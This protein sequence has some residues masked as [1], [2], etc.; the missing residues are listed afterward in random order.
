MKK[1]NVK[2]LVK[3]ELARREYL[4]Y[5]RLVH[6]DDWIVGKHIQLIADELNKFLEDSTKH[7]MVLSLPPQHGKSVLITETLP[8]YRAAKHGE[9]VI[10]GSYGDSLAR[11]FGRAN[12][13]K[14][15]EWGER[16]FGK[17]LT[18]SSDVDL[19]LDDGT[20]I[21]SRG[22]LGG[23]TGEKADFIVIDDPIKNRQEADSENQRDTIWN[24]FRDSF[25]SRLSA[26]GKMV[27][28]MT[29]W[30]EDD[31]VGR[32]TKI[33]PNCVV[34]NIPLEAMENDILGREVGDSLFPEIGKDKAW[35]ERFKRIYVGEEGLRSWNALYQ[36]MPTSQEGN[37]FKRHYFNRFKAT[38]QFVQTIRLLIISVD[39][40]FK[41]SKKS[42]YVSIGVWGKIGAD[43]YLIAKVKERM[44]FV[45]TCDAI[46]AICYQYPRATAKYIEDKANGSA[47][48]SVLNRKI[49]GFI[50][51]TPKESKEAR[52]QAVLPYFEAGNVHIYE[53]RGGD[54]LIEEA[55]QFPLGAHDDDVDMMTQAV[56]VLRRRSYSIPEYVSDDPMYPTQ[57][58]YKSRKVVRP[59][60]FKWK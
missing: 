28:I 49:G 32:L 60:K 44:D 55:A 17:K 59:Q 4:D 47:I 58:Q 13:R 9:R 8:S 15:E 34:V 19:E 42:D 41:D 56:N 25:Y 46:E 54:E 48:I 38:P 52:A 21:L 45:A 1:D 33:E 7:F 14:L 10:I 53:G 36:G 30:H 51:I 26:N 20:E 31:L 2:Q 57:K 35:M 12:R 27:I 39:A 23:V 3:E 50:G 37:L 29:R 5:C 22:V 40:A 43:M 11:K 24:E 16:L 18:R 6:G